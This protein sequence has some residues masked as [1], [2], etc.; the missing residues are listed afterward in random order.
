MDVGNDTTLE[1]A[2]ARTESDAESALK[3]AASV[4]SALK[5][6]RNAAQAGDLKELRKA[7]E[8]VDQSIAALRQQFANAKEGWNFDEETYLANGLYIKELLK[9]AR[10]MGLDIYEQDERLFCYPF[11]LRVLPTDRAILIDK[12]RDRRLRP[13][14]LIESLKKLQTK[15][16]RFKAEIFLE[17]LFSAYSPAVA[18][19]EGEKNVSGQVVPL[20]EIYALFTLLPNQSKEYT[21]QEFARDIYLLDQSGV[22]HTK[23]GYVVSFPASTGTKAMSKT[24]S[25]VTKHGQEKKYYGISFRREG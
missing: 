3:T 18:I 9:A 10:E 16:I 2:L 11:I 12:I 13:S 20:V 6:F 17:A 24:M 21:K 4:S 8:T 14:K 1:Q 5:R 15:P 7:V 23:E 25:V 19:R 22:D